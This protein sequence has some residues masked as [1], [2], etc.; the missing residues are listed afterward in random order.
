LSRTFATRAF[1]FA[2]SLAATAAFAQEKESVH[3]VITGG[4]NAGTYDATSD[5]GGCSYGL[6]GPGSWGNQLSLPKEKDPKKL[7]SLQLVVP[8][9]KK[10]AGGSK[11]FQMTVGFGPLMARSA[12]YT[13]DTRAT[14]PKKSGSGTVTVDDKGSTGKVTFSATTAAG[15]KLDGTID[16]KSVTRSGS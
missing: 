4:P 9:A 15:V 8:D 2:A 14:A 16:C 11:E 6:G 10:A 7:N 1:V 13:V 3:L 5:K 12:E